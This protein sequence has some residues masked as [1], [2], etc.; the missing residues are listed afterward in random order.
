[1][2]TILVAGF[3]LC[4]CKF[5]LKKFYFPQK[6]EILSP[7]AVPVAVVYLETNFLQD[8]HTKSSELTPFTSF[9]PCQSHYEL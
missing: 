7:S 8:L 9:E 5:P 3:A 6:K 2:Q 1:M 4:I